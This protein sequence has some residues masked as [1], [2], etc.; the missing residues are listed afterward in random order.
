[1]YTVHTMDYKL[2]QLAERNDALIETITSAT[3]NRGVEHTHNMYKWQGITER[4]VEAIY[5]GGM[6]DN[7]EK[8]GRYIF[9]STADNNSIQKHERMD[10][11][12]PPGWLRRQHLGRPSRC[13][14]PRRRSRA[15]RGCAAMAAASA[16]SFAAEFCVC[17]K[18]IA[19]WLID[20]VKV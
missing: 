11:F 17:S 14:P 18:S 1:M 12:R 4:K 15:W 9:S 6:V 2:L 19:T 3:L 16:T 10:W 20:W 13:S 8:P 5:T 7:K